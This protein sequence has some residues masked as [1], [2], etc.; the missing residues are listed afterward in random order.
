MHKVNEKAEYHCQ[1]GRHF[2]IPNSKSK[3][4]RKC[5]RC[6][7]TMYPQTK[8]PQKIETKVKKVF[9]SSL[10]ETMEYEYNFDD[11]GQIKGKSKLSNFKTFLKKVL[12]LFYVKNT[13]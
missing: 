7:R 1:C 10:E 13:R 5:P 6:A 11:M 8:E 12:S 9:P 4:P 2:I 3:E